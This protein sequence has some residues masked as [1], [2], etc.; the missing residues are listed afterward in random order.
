MTISTKYR[1]IIGCTLAFASGTASVFGGMFSRDA[2]MGQV[3]T[4]QQSTTDGCASAEEC[5]AAAA[6]SKERLSNSL[7]RDHV[8]A[9]KLSALLHVLIGKCSRRALSSIWPFCLRNTRT[10]VRRGFVSFPR[11]SI[12]AA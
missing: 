9:L 11:I 5:F 2:Y 12:P 6:F 10:G 3:A 8:A 7:T 4:P 1:L